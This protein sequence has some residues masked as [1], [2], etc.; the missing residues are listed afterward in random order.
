MLLGL[1]EALPSLVGKRFAAAKEAGALVFSATQL[2]VLPAAGVQYQLRYCPALA[3]K[4]VPVKAKE[5]KGP[6]PDPFENPSPDLLVAEIPPQLQNQSSGNAA[7]GDGGHIIVLNKF[8]VIPRHFILATKQFRN[9]TDLLEKE[10]LEAAFACIKAWKSHNDETKTKE[11]GGRLF[12]FFNSGDESGASQPHR[13]LQFV[14]IED[15]RDQ[16]EEDN[17]NDESSSS[18]AWVPLIDR[19]VNTPDDDSGFR[20]LPNLP[21][22]HFA[23]PLDESASPDTLFQSY[24][25][26]YRAAIDAVA[27]APAAVSGGGGCCWSPEAKIAKLAQTSGPAAISYNLAMTESA[28][29]IC[30]RRSETAHLLPQSAAEGENGTVLSGEVSLNGTIL[31]GTL[32]VKQELEWDDLRNRPDKINFLLAAVGLSNM[33]C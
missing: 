21:F 11:S 24:L 16:E 20:Q 33:D 32:M 4:P 26:L 27:S 22:K 17:N 14:P 15:M 30:P 2:A 23:V 12:A 31:A 19:V 6:K 7:G 18:S 8:P 3:K 28:M 25:S 5:N 1:P 10:D 29:M 9:Q 13:H